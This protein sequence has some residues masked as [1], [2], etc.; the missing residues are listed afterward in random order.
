LNRPA[1]PQGLAFNASTIAQGATYEQVTAF[2]MG[3][4]EFFLNDVGP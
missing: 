4:Q 2:V 1:D 3:S